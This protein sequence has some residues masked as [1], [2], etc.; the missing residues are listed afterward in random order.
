M[1]DLS[2]PETVSKAVADADLVV[3]A[4]PGFMGYST[5]ERVLK[6]GRPRGVTP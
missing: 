1:A 4:V 5:V 6:E 2:D 3:S